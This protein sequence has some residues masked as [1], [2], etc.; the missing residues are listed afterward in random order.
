MAAICRDCSRVPG[1]TVLE[2]LTSGHCDACRGNTLADRFRIPDAELELVKPVELRCAR[3][4]GATYYPYELAREPTGRL[5][6]RGLPRGKCREF[7]S[8]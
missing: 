6:C 1:L 3:G 8:C 5:R 4:H 7:V 2:T